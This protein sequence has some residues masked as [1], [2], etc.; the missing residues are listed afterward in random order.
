M[1]HVTWLSYSFQ[2]CNYSRISNMRGGIYIFAGLDRQR[3]WI[4][5]YIGQ[6]DNLAARISG[7][8]NWDKARSLGATHVHLMGVRKLILRDKIEREL[9]AAY[10]PALNV[11]L[12]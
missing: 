12:R 9:I 6:A 11:Q 10:Q 7:H 4:P 3:Q 8:E 2:V 1:N 5:Y